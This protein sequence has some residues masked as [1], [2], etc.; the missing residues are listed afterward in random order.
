MVATRQ[1]RL[2]VLQEAMRQSWLVH[3]RR[4]TTG[5]TLDDLQ[6]AGPPSQQVKYLRRRVVKDTKTL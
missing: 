6:Q 4:P 3:Y 2:P 5:P 1:W